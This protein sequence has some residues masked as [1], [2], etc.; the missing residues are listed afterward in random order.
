MTQDELDAIRQRWQDATPG[1]WVLDVQDG[2]VW[3]AYAPMRQIAHC[4][5]KPGAGMMH[6]KRQILA[7]AQFIA[8]AYGDIPT[9]LEYIAEL[10]AQIPTKIGYHDVEQYYA[11]D[12]G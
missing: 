9:L 1:P 6:D 11:E 10:Q 7:N 3:E 5:S 8:E 2:S 12:E 4:Q